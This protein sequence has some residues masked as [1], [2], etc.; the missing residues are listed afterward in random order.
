MG[1][2]RRQEAPGQEKRVTRGLWE[3]WGWG[4]RGQRE[5]LWATLTTGSGVCGSSP[6]ARAR[7]RV[8]GHCARQGQAL[9]MAGWVCSS[10]HSWRACRGPEGAAGMTLSPFFLNE[11]LTQGHSLWNPPLKN[12]QPR[13]PWPRGDFLPRAGPS[14]FT[15][16]RTVP[17]LTGSQ[18][19]A[20]PQRL[21]A[22]PSPGGG[23]GGGFQPWGQ[24]NVWPW[25]PPGTLRPPKTPVRMPH[26]RDQVRKKREPLWSTT[27]WVSREPAGQRQ[28]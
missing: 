21:P 10:G 6:Q 25:A 26:D 1:R 11:R 28:R 18:C 20:R 15:V 7:P 17:P 8:A 16:G 3:A 13:S 2:S 14:L 9:P 23:Q 19:G 4:E 24:D 22:S 5:A 12:N 27:W